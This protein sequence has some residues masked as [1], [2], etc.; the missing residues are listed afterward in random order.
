MDRDQRLRNYTE[1]V[2]YVSVLAFQIHQELKS[3]GLGTQV[4]TMDQEP[5]LAGSLDLDVSYS[6]ACFRD[7]K[8]FAAL[9]QLCYSQILWKLYGQSSLAMSGS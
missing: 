2:S 4:R 9:P 5:L 7:I 8:G 1:A 3:A 6:S